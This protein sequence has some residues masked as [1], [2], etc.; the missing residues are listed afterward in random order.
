MTTQQKNNIWIPVIT[1]LLSVFLSYVSVSARVDERSKM[2]EQ[3]M[4]QKVSKDEFNKVYD[5][6]KT[7]QTDQ[8]T[9]NEKLDQHLVKDSEIYKQLGILEG[10]QDK[11]K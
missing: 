11:N 6:L 1:L 2:L 7:I 9:T 3:Q 10:K 4:E 5:I 8:K